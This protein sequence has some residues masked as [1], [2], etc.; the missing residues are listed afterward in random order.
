MSTDASSLLL[1]VSVFALTLLPGLGVAWLV[2]QRKRR[3]REAR[4]SPLS[5]DLLRGPGHTLRA[6]LDDGRIDLMADALALMVLPAGIFASMFGWFLIVGALPSRWVLVLACVGIL[7]WAL[8]QGRRV[9][10]ASQQVDQWWL[11]LDAEMAAGQELDQLMR[12]GAEVFH[13]FPAT[14]RFNI[15]HVVV[16]RQ[17][18]F[19]VETKGFRKPN[20]LQGLEAARVAFDGQ[21]LRFPDFAS[22]KPLKQAER[23]A[24]WLEEWLTS[25][26]GERV[27]VTPVVALPGWFVEYAGRGPVRVISGAQLQKHLLKSSVRE[28]IGAEQMQRV[29][30]QVEQRC[31]DV[32]P[33]YRP[34]QDEG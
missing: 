11:G 28:P 17:G 27:E 29:V 30:H 1:G 33:S 19:A 32:K 22:D 12:Q 23:N 21:M 31:R 10:R 18:V 24:R 25:A 15:D 16:A 2:L 5:Q 20:H 14:D 8:V 9:W 13:D 7:V 6:Q 26:T 4:R 34:P 3:A